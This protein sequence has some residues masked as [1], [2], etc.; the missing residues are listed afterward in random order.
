MP[1]NDKSLDLAGPFA[2]GHQAGIAV[3][4]FDRIFARVAISAMD[5]NRVAA[6]AFRHFGG[7]HLCHRRFFVVRAFLFFEPGSFVEHSA[8]NFNFGRGVCQHP[9]DGLLFGDGLPKRL[10]FAWHS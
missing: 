9:L 8:R 4:P 6:D 1:C 5:L 3:D 7:E 2:D 10:T